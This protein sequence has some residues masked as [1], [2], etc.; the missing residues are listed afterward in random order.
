MTGRRDIESTWHVTLPSGFDDLQAEVEWNALRLPDGSVYRVPWPILTSKQIVG[1]FQLREDWQLP[2]AFVPLIGDF[3]DL[4]GLDYSEG[5]P[6]VIALDDARRTRR[7]F[8]DFDGFLAARF[9][10]DE[11]PTDTSGIIEDESWLD[12]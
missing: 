2:D 9:L 10:A 3:H 1:A 7:L 12:I 5:S 11:T 4:V 6:T 8:D